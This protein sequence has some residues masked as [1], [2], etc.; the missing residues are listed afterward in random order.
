M[1]PRRREI[2]HAVGPG[3]DRQRIIGDRH[4][5][6]ADAGKLA[7]ILAQMGRTR[8]FDGADHARA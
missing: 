5:D 3:E 8:A 6:A 2:E 7:G 4:I 1:K